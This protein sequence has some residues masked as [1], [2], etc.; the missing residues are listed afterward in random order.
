MA[1]FKPDQNSSPLGSEII[2]LQESV[3]PTEG[4]AGKAANQIAVFEK[5]AGWAGC[6]L[7]SSQPDCII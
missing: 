5:W 7:Q 3:V 6:K 2:D 4:G 1:A